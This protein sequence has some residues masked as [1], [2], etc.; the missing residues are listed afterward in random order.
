MNDKE[1]VS[2]VDNIGQALFEMEFKGK[3]VIKIAEI[4]KALNAVRNELNNREVVEDEGK[5]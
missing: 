4:L 5:E 2:V 1:L 3:D